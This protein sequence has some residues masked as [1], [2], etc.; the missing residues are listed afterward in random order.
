MKTIVASVLNGS[1]IFATAAG[2]L[3]LGAASPSQGWVIA[4][5]VTSLV[6][7]VAC[8]FVAIGGLE[9]LQTH[10]GRDGAFCAGLATA[11]TVAL[12]AAALFLISA[13]LP[14]GWLGPD[15]AKV[16]LF[17]GAA[18]QAVLLAILSRSASRV[19]SRNL[20]LW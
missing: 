2:F 13:L 9:A 16:W 8:T 6:L 4:I 1:L 17:A 11:W 20:K 7:T 10:R 15:A 19:T 5:Y 3:A 14:A 12:V 18:A